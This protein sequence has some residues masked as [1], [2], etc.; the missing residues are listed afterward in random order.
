MKKL[1]FA[2]VF[3]LLF[4][5]LPLAFGQETLEEAPYIE[6]YVEIMC[7]GPWGLTWGNLTGNPHGGT[8]GEGNYVYGPFD[9]EKYFGNLMVMLVR[10]APGD[11]RKP[12][13]ASILIYTEMGLSVLSGSTYDDYIFVSH[14]FL[15]G[16]P[17]PN[18][19]IQNREQ[20]PIDPKETNDYDPRSFCLM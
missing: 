14:K 4:S 12:L 11:G 9:P 2:L 5:F 17:G 18:K 20:L 19:P 16:Q 15:Y 6:I 7:E 13:V 1:I 10:I 3:I 8:Q